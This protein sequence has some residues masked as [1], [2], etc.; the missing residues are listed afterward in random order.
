MTERLIWTLKREWLRRV[1]VIRGM[2][3][4]GQL[5][6]EFSQY[7]NHWWGHSTIG[8][9]VPSVIHRG[10]RWQRPDRS[11]KT[12]SGNTD[13]RFFPDTRLTAFRLAA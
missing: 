2:D 6:D 5:L 3:H 7:Y 10:D 1:L 4:F 12:L 11:A 8:G 9:A 13:R